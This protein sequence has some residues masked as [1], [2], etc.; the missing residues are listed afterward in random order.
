VN[1]RRAIFGFA[2][3]ATFSGAAGTACADPAFDAFRQL[4]IATG[5]DYPAVVA[6]ADAAGWKPID[7][8]I[9]T[10]KGV[11]VSDKL[12]R[13]RTIAGG[14]ATLSAW[15]GTAPPNAV[16][17]C[18]V[19]LSKGAFAAARTSVQ[20]WAGFAPQDSSG[21]KAVFRFTQMGAAPRPLAASDFDSA[22]AAAGL[23]IL[24]ITGGSGGVNLDLVRIKK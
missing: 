15:R 8:T 10:M 18:T 6:A 17:T 9:M 22:A 3:A 16:S 23:E 24:T 13:G 11:A 19:K 7:V 21:Q 5:A 14:D 4:C 1:S 2:I 20:A 12:T